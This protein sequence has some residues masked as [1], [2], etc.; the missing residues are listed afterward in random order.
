MM[1]FLMV[2]DAYNIGDGMEEVRSLASKIENVMTCSIL[3]LCP[4]FWSGD[5]TPY[6]T[7]CVCLYICGMKNGFETKT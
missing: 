1:I 2:K 3:L 7:L 5:P 4:D 6:V